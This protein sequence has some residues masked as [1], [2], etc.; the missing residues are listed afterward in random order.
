MVDM[1]FGP[2][3]AGV[4]GKELGHSIADSL[5]C[6]WL[7]VLCWLEFL[8]KG[9]AIPMVTP[10]GGHGFCP[11][12]AGVFGK[13]LGHSIVDSLWCTWLLVLWWL[14]FLQFQGCPS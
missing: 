1:G 11:M 9:L 7:F 3:L 5:W 8:A 13:E 12:L 2:M 4:F 14:D 10:Y 6:T